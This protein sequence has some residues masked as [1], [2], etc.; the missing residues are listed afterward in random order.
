MSLLLFLS[1]FSLNLD[2]QTDSLFRLSENGIFDTVLDRTGNKYP[3]VRI[4]I[5][6]TL[7]GRWDSVLPNKVLSCT[8]GYF[9]IY[10]EPGCG[11]DDDGDTDNVARRNVLCRVLY[12]LSQFI[13]SPLTTSG[14]KVNLWVRKKNNVL[15]VG[16]AISYGT[17]F[18]PLPYSNTTSGIADNASW[19][20]IHSGADGYKNLMPY[21]AMNSNSFFHLIITFDFGGSYSWH[22]DL[23]TTPSS[24]EYDLYTVALKE[25]THALGFA[26]E[27]SGDGSPLIGGT[28]NYYS[29]YDRFLK[30][31]SGVPLIVNSGSIGMY[32]YDFNP[33]ISSAFAVLSPNAS[34]CIADSTDCDTAV[35]YVGGITQA[36]YTPNCYEVG[37]SLSNFEDECWGTP[38]PAN[39]NLYFVESNITGVASMKRYLKPEERTVLADIGFSVDTVYGDTTNHNFHNYGG[40]I[41]TGITVA[42]INDGFNSGGAREICSDLVYGGVEAGD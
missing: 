31:H 34:N 2:A 24:G 28:Y 8:S 29:R 22:T 12:D 26:S 38:T 19:L 40:S 20:T 4:A 6:D 1:F 23:T 13:H 11:M 39:N 5:D 33:S 32:G 16:S 7:R 21:S 37:F 10:L 35:K 41:S 42:G 25:V 15:G 9:Q 14:A 30:T 17:S 27:I 18:F 3:I 36:V